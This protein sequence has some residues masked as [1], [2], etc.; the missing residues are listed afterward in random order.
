MEPLFVALGL[1]REPVRARGNG[2]EQRER[3]EARGFLTRKRFLGTSADRRSYVVVTV[4]SCQQPL[5]PCVGRRD[6]NDGYTGLTGLR[7]G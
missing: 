4:V 3:R 7:E 5:P 6:D 2:G 1:Q